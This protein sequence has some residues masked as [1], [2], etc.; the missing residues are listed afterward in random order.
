MGLLD[1]FKKEK[2]EDV[3]RK[4]VRDAFEESVK[5]TKNQLMGEPM[6]DGMLI[7]AAIGTMRLSLLEAP[8]LQALGLMSNWNSEQIIDEECKRVVR[9]YLK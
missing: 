2:P 4:K 8:E 3:F 9:K 6:L 5:D 1:L 7:Q